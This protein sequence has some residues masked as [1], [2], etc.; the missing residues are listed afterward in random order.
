MFPIFDAAPIQNVPLF[1]LFIIL[2]VA[3]VVAIIIGIVIAIKE[4]KK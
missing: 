3:I 2:A 1:V 4:S